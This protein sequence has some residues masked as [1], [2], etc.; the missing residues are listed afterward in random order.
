MDQNCHLLVTTTIHL[1][2][3]RCRM[4]PHLLVSSWLDSRLAV[5]ARRY[6]SSVQ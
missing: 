4:V 3:Q 1:A 2:D 6:I 5:I